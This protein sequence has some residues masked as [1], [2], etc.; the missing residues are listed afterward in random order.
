VSLEIELELC[1]SRPIT[2]RRRRA[3]GGRRASNWVRRRR[4]GFSI[5][6]SSPSGNRCTEP[7]YAAQREGVDSVV[8]RTFR[9]YGQRDQG[10]LQTGVLPIGPGEIAQLDNDPNFMENGVLRIATLGGKA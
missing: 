5:R 9:R 3:G 7:A 2:S 1:V 8:V 10:E 4:L 6:T